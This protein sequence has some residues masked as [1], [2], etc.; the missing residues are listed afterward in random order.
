MELEDVMRKFS[1]LLGALSI[2]AA[3][4]GLVASSTAPAKADFIQGSVGVAGTDVI[5]GTTILFLNAGAS[6]NILTGSFLSTLGP[7]ST[8]VATFPTGVAYDWTNLVTSLGGTALF[9]VTQGGATGSLTL[10][11]ST[12]VNAIPGTDVT[13]SGT[14]FLHLT[15]FADTQGTWG[16]SSQPAGG[17]GSDTLLFNFSAGATA[18]PGP[19]VGAGIPGLLAGAAALYGLARRRRQKFA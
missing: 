4:G 12:I 11:T 13:L 5:S 18:V 9:T 8:A 1:R 14:W 15:G 3:V 19:I 16:L 6:V 10:T 2:A 7:L 17:A